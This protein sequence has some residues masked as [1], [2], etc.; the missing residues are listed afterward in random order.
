MKQVI[1][2]RTG[3]LRVLIFSFFVVLSNFVIGLRP[4]LL[5]RCLQLVV[6]IKRLILVAWRLCFSC[7]WCSSLL[8]A[9][10]PRKEEVERPA[11]RGKRKVCET[12]NSCLSLSTHPHPHPHP[13]PF[14]TTYQV[15]NSVYYTFNKSE[16]VWSNFLNAPTANFWWSI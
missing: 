15:R 12:Y 10:T 8:T 16:T 3:R 13:I 1:I 7:S 4:W 14:V 5:W 2:T 6:I 9:P 11:A